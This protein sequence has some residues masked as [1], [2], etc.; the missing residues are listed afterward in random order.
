[1]ATASA[2]TQVHVLEAGE[3][4]D[5]ITQVLSGLR[6]VAS[7]QIVSHG[8]SGGIQLGASWLDLQ[9]L[10][11]SIG[12]LKSWRGSLT[13]DADIL[14]YGCNVAQDNLGQAFVNQLAELTGADV[15]ASIDL[16]GNTALGG[17][18]ALE[19]QTGSIDDRSN[20]LIKIDLQYQNLLGPTEDTLNS[21]TAISDSSVAWG[22]YSG[23]GKLDLII[24]GTATTGGITKL[25][26]NNGSGTLIQ[27]TSITLP[28]VDYGTVA[29]GDYSGDGKLDLIVTGYNNSN[30]VVLITKLYKNN[31]SGTLIEDTT[32]ALPGVYNSSVAWGDYSGD[33]KLDLLLTGMSVNGAIA[34]LYK[35]DGTGTLVE[36]TNIALPG[37]ENGRAAWGD[38]SGDGKLDLVLTGATSN[39]SITK[40]YKNNGTGTLIADTNTVL[41]GLFHGSVAWGD[42]SGDGKLDLIL[43]GTGSNASIT[44]LYKNNGTGTLIADTSMTLPGVDFSSVVW[45]DYSGDGK[46]DL[47]LTGFTG[48]GAIAKLYKNDGAGLLVEATNLMLPGVY[49]GSMAWGD[50]NDDNN[51]DLIISGYNSNNAPITK[52]YQ[53]FVINQKPIVTL[54]SSPPIVYTEADTP[55]AIIPATATITDPDNPANFNRGQL[56]VKVIAGYNQLDQLTISATNRI[57]LTGNTVAVD[58]IAIGTFTGGENSNDLVIT[59]NTAST[60]TSV[61]ALL[62]AIVY[63][64][65]GTNLKITGET[66]TLSITMSD[67]KGGTS[68][69]LERTITVKGKVKQRE[70]IVRNE[71]TGAI[72]MQFYD[73]L[74]LINQSSIYRGTVSNST[75]ATGLTAVWQIKGTYDFNNDGNAD[76]LWQNIVNGS[77]VVWEMKG[78]I[79]TKSSVFTYQYNGT[80]YDLSSLGNW[81]IIGLGNHQDLPVLFFQD[82]N[83]GEILTRRFSGYELNLT[84]SGVVKTGLGATLK[85][86]TDWKAIQLADFNTDRNTD[87]LFQSKTTGQLVVWNLK[88]DVLQSSTSL[89]IL[90]TTG[91]WMVQSTGQLTKGDTQLDLLLYNKTTGGLAIDT[92]KNGKVLQETIA[93]GTGNPSL[94]KPGKL[95]DL[96]GDG[97]TEA[98]WINSTGKLNITQLDLDAKTAVVAADAE[99]KLT[100]LLPGWTVAAIDEFQIT[101]KTNNLKPRFTLTTPNLTTQ[102]SRT[103]S[104]QIS[105]DFAP[106]LDDPT[107]M[108]LGYYITVVSR[109]QLIKPKTALMIDNNG[110]LNITTADG[111]GSGQIVLSITVRDSGTENNISDAKILTIDVLPPASA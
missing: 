18:W 56:V 82:R 78:N 29:W 47:L 39:G 40:L 67:G 2:G 55:I 69:A 65:T 77:T 81:E 63:R 42:Y 97:K 58:G 93:L 101:P 73:G 76:V 12:Q 20:L 54:P 68:T 96:N 100:A 51:L 10:Q 84:A 43:S 106:G 98:F 38:Y 15:A 95:N 107:R 83:N 87:V 31:G 89:G 11:G 7:V 91:P 86:G 110:R 108:L 72:V 53:G 50:Y 28:Q 22:D 59:L 1:M 19:Y 16:T 103:V 30:G 45:G 46:L 75:I 85:P 4:L 80:K 70:A 102:A 66:R 60:A 109:S 32:V 57:T 88:N 14:L 64:N 49:Y 71:S 27:D 17:N 13:A 23:D 6:D 105:I 94:G 99:T 33:G 21:L 35:N 79:I 25:Y 8:R 34:K 90:A 5:R 36:A 62:K 37:V 9:G 44:K 3:G 26:K 92:L 41:P 48:N 24:T 74:Q 111:V 52:L 104:Q 61:T